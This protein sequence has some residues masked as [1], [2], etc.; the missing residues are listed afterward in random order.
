MLDMAY[1]IASKEKFVELRAS[2][3]TL[4]KAAEKLGIAYN[5]AVGWEKALKERIENQKAIRIEELQEKYLI[6][7]EKRIELFGEQLLAINEELKKRDL[8]EIPTPKLFGMMIKCM[9]ALEEEMVEPVFWSDEEM[10]RKRD[11]QILANNMPLAE[12]PKKRVLNSD[13]ARSKDLPIGYKIDYGKIIP[14]KSRK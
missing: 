7:K 13:S 2:G 10:E 4:A 14:A 8:S 1:P 12:M 6:S 11:E 5:T 9:K 3:M